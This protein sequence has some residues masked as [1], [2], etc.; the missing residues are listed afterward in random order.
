MTTGNTIVDVAST[1]RPRANRTICEHSAVLE[2]TT[3]AGICEPF[4]PPWEDL[5]RRLSVHSLTPEEV[6]S[7]PCRRRSRTRSKVFTED[8][9]ETWSAA[10]TRSAT[11]DEVE[12]ERPGGEC[13]LTPSLFDCADRSTASTSR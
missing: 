6:T 2:E 8:V 7:R 12:S 5:H 3:E 9:V 4:G 11:H 13:G 10:K 1:L